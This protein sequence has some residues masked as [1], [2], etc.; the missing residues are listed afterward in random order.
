MTYVY[1]D[2]ILPT[3]LGKL[4]LL[5]SRYR[6]NV[7]V[8]IWIIFPIPTAKMISKMRRLLYII[9]ISRPISS[10]VGT[11]IEAYDLL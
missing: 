2:A 7:R 10:L 8:E 1:L 5:P 6:N 4:L 3:L 9:D 11:I